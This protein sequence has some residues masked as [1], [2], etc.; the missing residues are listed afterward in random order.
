M[1]FVEIDFG[2]PHR[3]PDL[4][5]QRVLDAH[6]KGARQCGL[7]IEALAIN[8][9]NDIGL[10]ARPETES[11]ALVRNILTRAIHAA[12]YLEATRIIVPGFR[13]SIIKDEK[14]FIAT[15]DNLSYAASLASNEGI[16]VS[17]EA[18]LKPEKTLELIHIIG[19]LNVTIQFD[20][21]NPALDNRNAGE[22]WSQLLNVAAPNVHVKDI[23]WGNAQDVCLGEGR[24]N[25]NAVFLAFAKH[26]WPRGFVLEGDYRQ[27]ADARINR[28][29]TY[30]HRMIG[31]AAAALQG[32]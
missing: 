6:K 21:G 19:K 16:A 31:D 17:Y 29:L 8:Q 9:L 10:T 25:L 14:D 18:N 11:G 26:G 2:G 1:T 28:D 3:G 27:D 15:A 32:S 24:A 7:T 4:G 5:K 12:R 13:R 22:M 23:P 30:L 20:T